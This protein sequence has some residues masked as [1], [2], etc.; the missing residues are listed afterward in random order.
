MFKG[1]NIILLK[2]V[3]LKL[4]FHRLSEDILKK[5]KPNSNNYF[6]IQ[7]VNYLKQFL[8]KLV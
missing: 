2:L 5:C 8:Q 4:V 7:N 6:N 3:T 1:Y